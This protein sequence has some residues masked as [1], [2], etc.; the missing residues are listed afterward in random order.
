[1]T[2]SHQIAIGSK[3][4][5]RFDAGDFNGKF[6]RSGWRVGIVTAHTRVGERF[7]PGGLPTYNVTLRDGNVFT[8]CAAECVKVVS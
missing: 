5:V 2:T 8:H 4:K 7:Y 6:Y 1:M 3:V